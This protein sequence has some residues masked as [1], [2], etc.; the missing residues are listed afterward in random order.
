MILFFKT[1]VIARQFFDAKCTIVLTFSIVWNILN[2]ML[3]VASSY[4]LQLTSDSGVEMH[5]Y[6]NFLNCMEYTQYTQSLNPMLILASS[7]KLQLASDSGVQR[8]TQDI[9][10]QHRNLRRVLPIAVQ[11][12]WE[13]C[14]VHFWGESALSGGYRDFRAS[15]KKNR[16][17]HVNSA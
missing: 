13:K 7:H 17:S 11:C 8:N 2:P 9:F 3:I 16:S 10:W 14:T 12:T 15:G 6:A 1:F 5:H 4:K